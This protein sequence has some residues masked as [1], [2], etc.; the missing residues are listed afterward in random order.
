MSKTLN[1]VDTAASEYADLLVAA[2]TSIN[3][4]N[5]RRASNNASVNKISITNYH[6][7]NTA[8]VSLYIEQNPVSVV[9]TVYNNDPTITHVSN[10]S[11]VAGMEVTGTGIPA[12]AIVD[13]VTSATVFELSAST[14]GG[15]QEDEV[16][17]LVGKHY[18]ISNVEIPSGATLV[19]DDKIT[20]DVTT[21]KLVILKTNAN[22]RITVII[23]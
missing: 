18:I 17:A 13:S 16:L 6:A 22:T 1:L 3:R 19:L 11:I 14:T 8:K 20:L 15:L 4:A 10:T 12:S 9:T 5:N 7:S 2:D 21:H 23:D